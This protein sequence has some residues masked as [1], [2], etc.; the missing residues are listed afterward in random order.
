MSLLQSTNQKAGLSW[1]IL[2]LLKLQSSPKPSRRPLAIDL[3]GEKSHSV[4]K[5]ACCGIILV[6]DGEATKFFCAQCH[7]TCLCTDFNCKEP[8]TVT[9]IS[10]MYVDQLAA[11]CLRGEHAKSAHDLHL[12]LKPLLDYLMAAFSSMTCLNHS[13]KIKKNSR[14]AHYSSCNLDLA[15]VRKTFEILLLL[16]SKR[17]LFC[18]L[19]GASSCL[20]RLPINLSEDPQNLYWTVVLFEIPILHK[21]LINWDNRPSSAPLKSMAE[22]PAIQAL[23][24]DITKRV[25]GVL[26]QAECH[27]SGNYLASWFLKLSKPEFSSKVDLINLYISFQ[28]KKYLFLANNPEATRRTSLGLQDTSLPLFRRRS[29]CTGPILSDD[30]YFQLSQLKEEV[31]HPTEDTPGW[32]RLPVNAAT[33]PRKP[34]TKKKPDIKI[35]LH[36]YSS[37]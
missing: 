7:T 35:R 5:C 26:S 20:K 14:R 37:N 9:P 30:E 32:S 6:S 3:A 10:S 13:F 25:V 4:F 19:T 23:C 1:R 28:M 24:Y 17:P 34:T 33:L 12:K 22:V 31:E 36:Q 18:A 15:D 2:D 21:A 16:P 8:S 29:S 27:L 11:N